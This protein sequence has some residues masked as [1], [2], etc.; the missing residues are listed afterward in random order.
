MW[1]VAGCAFLLGAYLFWARQF[2]SR[3]LWST[4]IYA[5]YPSDDQADSLP[6]KLWIAKKQAVWEVIDVAIS[7]F[8]GQGFFPKE[9]KKI[10]F[11]QEKSQ[12]GFYAHH[13]SISNGDVEMVAIGEKGSSVELLDVKSFGDPSG[14]IPFSSN[15]DLKSFL[16]NEL[17]KKFPRAKPEK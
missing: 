3:A 1:I 15:L 9:V 16:E 14:G 4:K 6:S 2:E 10:P 12:F 17:D 7:A 11:P 5:T 8:Y 13:Y